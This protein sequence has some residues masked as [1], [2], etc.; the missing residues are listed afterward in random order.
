MSDNLSPA[1]AAE[2]TLLQIGSG[3][4]PEAWT[5][6]ANVTDMNDSGMTATMV[7]ITSHSSQA[8]FMQFI[9]TLLNLGVLSA[10][11]FWVPQNDTHRN[12][13]VGLIGGIRY[14]W[15]NRLKQEYRLRYTDG[16]SSDSWYA[17]IEDI[18][19]TITVAGVYEM[20][21]KIHKTGAPTNF[22]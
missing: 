8:P 22:V 6:L 10:K 14:N 17:Y 2:G 5:T 18:S 20:A 9:P 1:L 3:A 12:A 15:M 21:C 16:I 13:I 11:L 4:S 7:N 19:T